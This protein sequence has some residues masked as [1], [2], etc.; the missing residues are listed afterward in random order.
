MSEN[1]IV[2]QHNI[3]ALTDEILLL[4]EEAVNFVLLNAI[5]IGGK[6]CE[7]KALLNHGEWSEW[8][9]NRVDFS[10]RHATDLMKMY[11]EY[12]SNQ[13]SLFSSNSQALANLSYT[14]ALALLAVPRE[15]REEFAAEVDAENISSRELEKLIKER[16]DAIKAKEEAEHRA[17]QYSLAQERASKAEKDV[18]VWQH[19]VSELNDRLSDLQVGFDKAK[20][21]EKK[22]KDKVK[23]LKENP[24][25][26]QELIDKMQAEADTKAAQ[27]ATAD[28][29][30]QTR[31]LKEQ[32]ESAEK[33]RQAAEQ[34]AAAASKKAEELS[35]KVRMSNPDV[36][37]FKR[38]FEQTQQD[39]IKLNSLKDKISLS[40][41]ELGEKFTAA[42]SAFAKQYIKE[43]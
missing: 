4:K 43:S 37:E 26:P 2:P 41:A 38:L 39:M 25:I 17:E 16:N 34:E 15:E 6:L 23:A 22:A 28:I 11:Q 14:K 7:A 27:K 9:E 20:E 12:G 30:E 29:E 18:A 13:I 35:V 5:K 32:L 42:I 1:Q 10:Q 36:I 19:K 24:Q 33:A 3:D 21:A 8:L 40:D 31:Q